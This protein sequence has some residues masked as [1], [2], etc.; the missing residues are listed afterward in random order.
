MRQSVREISIPAG[1]EIFKEGEPGDGIYI[2][3][4]GLVQISAVLNDAD[5]VVLARLGPGEMF[6]EMAVLDQNPRSATALAEIGTEVFFYF[7]R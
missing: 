1:K 5:R 6:G 4:S 7:P 2:V 3:K